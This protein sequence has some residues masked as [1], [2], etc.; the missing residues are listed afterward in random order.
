VRLSAGDTS[1]PDFELKEGLIRFRGCIWIGNDKDIQL[2]LVKSLHDSAVGGHSGFHATYHRVKRLFA[3]TGMKQLVQQVVREC[4]TCQQAKTECCPPAGLLQ[5]LNV[6]G[7]P[8]EVIT[9][10]FI[11]GLPRSANHDTILVIVDKFSK[12]SHFLALRHP[13]TAL[14]V[15]KLYM[16][17]VFKIHGLPQAIVSDRDRIFTSAL[18]QE[19]FRLSKT[20]LR[21]SSSYHPQSDGQTERVN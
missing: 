9:L 11:E 19:L 2:Q 10:D 14:D 16:T 13:F 3:W 12:N 7:Q 6:P 15:A 20:E 21:L 5:P 8:W 4:A 1:E 17:H 18:W